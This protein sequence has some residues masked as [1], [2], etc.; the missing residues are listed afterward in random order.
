MKTLI[1][2]TLLALASVGGAQTV[3]GF[4]VQVYAQVTDPI[5]IDFAP[6]G[7]IYCGR[8]NTGSGGGNSDALRLYR[9]GPCAVDVTLFS[10]TA[11]TD[12]D[13]VVFDT[14][15]SYTGIA[16]SVVV[17][18]FISGSSGRLTAVRP[19][20][21]IT[22]VYNGTLV[23]NP[24]DMLFNAAGKLIVCDANANRV[25][26]FDTINTTTV[27][28]SHVGVILL[29][30]DP[31]GNLYTMSTAG[32]IQSHTSTGT[33]LNAT[34]ANIS[35]SANAGMAFGPDASSFSNN[36]Y[37]VRNGN[38]YKVTTA[39]VVT[40]I[41]TGFS[42]DCTDIAFGPDKAMY[43]SS[44][45]TDKIIRV[46]APGTRTI[47][48]HINFQDYVGVLPTSA[49]LEVRRT[50]DNSLVSNPTVSLDANQNFSGVSVPT[51]GC[52]YVTHKTGTWLRGRETVDLRL[53]T[54]ASVNIQMV[55][56]DCNDDNTVDLSDYT[57]IA[58]AFNALP[59][60]GNWDARADVNGDGV[61]DLTDYIIVVTN[62]N[63]LGA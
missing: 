40:T 1:A 57:I 50:G 53:P 63:S 12:P 25:V 48:G 5:R 32:A 39:G 17:G 54:T 29:S 21:S 26:R 6:D 24:A 55:N 34:L 27:L 42:V 51:S 3:P 15:G 36:L 14:T 31:A 35:G 11:I 62:F 16:N 59:A 22:S 7:S 20:G 46:A 45:G 49:L 30:A 9:V 18:S 60:S 23:S 28:F 10:N 56:G 61:V 13:T 43:I 19:D 4:D 37:V 52:Y 44:F 8:D 47:S 38:L 41:G 2:L 58:V 33:V